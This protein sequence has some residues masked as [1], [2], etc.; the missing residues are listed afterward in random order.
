MSEFVVDRRRITEAVLKL[1]KPEYTK[2]D[3][4]VALYKWWKNPRSTGGRRLTEEGHK[5]F[6]LA[7]IEYQEFDAG[8]AFYEGYMK[9]E[10]M[11]DRRMP[12]P[13]YLIYQN[14]RK[15]I[16][17]YDNRISTMISLY[18]DFNDYLKNLEDRK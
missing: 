16:R 18:G 12:C 7:D 1:L 5:Y 17:V 13:Y 4:E 3:I 9:F 15:Y 2:S 14:K 6:V 10:L 11:L 8:E